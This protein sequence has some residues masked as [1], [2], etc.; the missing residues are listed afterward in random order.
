MNSIS[1]ASYAGLKTNSWVLA[2]VQTPVDL[3]A[4][5]VTDL[6]ILPS[7]K[8][9]DVPDRVIRV[10]I[11][12]MHSATGAAA[13]A[14]ATTTSGPAEVVIAVSAAAASSPLGDVVAGG[15]RGAR[16]GEGVMRGKV[17]DF[18]R[19]HV[20]SH[21]AQEVGRMHVGVSAQVGMKAG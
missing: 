14:T 13:A 7:M 5:C 19:G 8:V 6:K 3:I 11:L 1:Y 9:A 20:I 18:R 10:V 16:I 21:V 2:I 17:R 15:R 12:K 4:Y